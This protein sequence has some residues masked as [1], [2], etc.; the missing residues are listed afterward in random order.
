V[1][2]SFS[3]YPGAMVSGDDFYVT[4]PARLMITETTNGVM[5]GSLFTA[6]TTRTVPYWIR[7]V[8]ANKMASTARQWMDDF[9]L[10]NSG[11][12]NNQWIVVD[13]K[14]FQPGQTLT[15][16]V[17][18]IGEQIPGYFVTS[19]ITEI[20]Y[21][22]YWAS[23]NIPYFPFVWNISGYLPYY[24]KYGDE[25]SWH[26]CARAR[27]FRRDAPAVASIDDMQH[28][29]RYNQWQ[30]D[31]L[32][33]QDACKGISARCDLNPPWV[34]DPLNSYSPFG[35][36]DSKITSDELI[37]SRA[38]IAVNG[39]AWDSQSPYAWT[40]QFGMYTP[41]YGHPQVFAFEFVVQAPLSP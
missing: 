21:A 1:G 24:Q 18:W 9:G 3:S 5:N 33:K 6:V 41:H 28:I 38:A 39:P 27:I 36:T 25:W 30:T 4:S 34:T 22:S 17:L 7:C 40:S 37:A 23:Y 26:D 31:P 11:T 16:G 32:S 20:L 29:M 14:A 8:V 19:D 2:V 15:S 10:Y 13:Y 12:Y 35:G